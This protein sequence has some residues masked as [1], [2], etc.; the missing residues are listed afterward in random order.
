MKSKI[1]VY[2]GI[3]LASFAVGRYFPGS[4]RTQYIESAVESTRDKDIGGNLNRETR[5]INRSIDRSVAAQHPKF[6]KFDEIA[7][8]AQKFR[9][10]VKLFDGKAEN[11]P[12]IGFDENFEPSAAVCDFFDISPEDKKKL[13]DLCTNNRNS[14]K[15]W[16][17]KNR[18]ILI[19][20]TSELVY[21]I[22][23][24]PIFAK[25]TKEKFKEDLFDIVG[26]DGLSLL[27]NSIDELYNTLDGK[28]VVGIVVGDHDNNTW[29]YKY[30]VE[31]FDQKNNLTGRQGYTDY[32]KKANPTNSPSV[33]PSRYDHLLRIE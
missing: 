21:E 31:K 18:M 32:V 20:N 29:K 6:E 11:I 15:N 12:G 25:E 2:I 8:D 22:P 5:L 24:N 17:L 7:A 27:S 26:G 33:I 13:E 28:R 9:K 19:S 10:I 1:F 30:T 14:I 16:E 4:N 3:A 23:P